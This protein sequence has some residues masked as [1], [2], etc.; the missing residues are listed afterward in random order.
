[1][2]FYIGLYFKTIMKWAWCRRNSWRECVRSLKLLHHVY[3]T[4]HWSN[5]YL[6]VILRDNYHRPYLWSLMRR[7][8]KSLRS[9]SL[10]NLCRV[11]WICLS[12]ILNNVQNISILCACR[13][14]QLIPSSNSR[15]LT[16]LVFNLLQS[17]ILNDDAIALVF[18]YFRCSYQ[19]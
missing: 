11:F 12:Y 14:R 8:I 10:C 1:M 16:P 4:E 15:I 13:R 5:A 18:D 6:L 7:D 2:C 3:F 17:G 19:L 9:N